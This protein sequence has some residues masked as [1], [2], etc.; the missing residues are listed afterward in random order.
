VS[1]KNFLFF[2]KK[3][4][5]FKISGE[6]KFPYVAKRVRV[7][8]RQVT[9]LNPIE[10]ALDEMRM[11]VAELEQVVLSSPTDAKKLQLRLQ[12]SVCVQVNAGPLAYANAFL[13]PTKKKLYTDLQVEALKDVFL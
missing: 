5:K 7:I 6:Y 3:N 4:R 10:V 9:E 8:R 12:G 2:F 11:R 1:S 13:E